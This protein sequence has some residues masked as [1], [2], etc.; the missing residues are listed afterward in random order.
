M[1]LACAAGAC[2]DAGHEGA[3]SDHFDGERFFNPGDAFD[4]NALDLIRYWWES[5]PGQW[6]R[7]LSTP[8]GPPPP[9]TVAAGALRVTFINHASVLI[10]A[11]GVNLLTDPIW[12]QRA[13]PVSWAG[14]QRYVPPGIAFDDLPEIDAVLISHDHYDHLD[15]PTLI[16]LRERFDPVIVVGLGQSA[17]LRRHGLINTVELDWWGGWKMPSGCTLWGAPSRHWTGRLTG[18]RNRSLWMSYVI[19]TPGGPVY[20]AGDTGYG[21]H[22]AQTRQRYGAMRYALLPIGAYKPRWLTDYQHMDPAQALQAHVDL[23][24]AAS[25]AV[26][27]G[28]FE[29]SDDGQHEP[30]RDLAAALAAR[31]MD[32]AAFH[33]PEFGGGYDVEPLIPSPGCSS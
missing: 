18:G 1:L 14:P 25:L 11:D 22:F 31:G 33:A 4:K 32:A 21:P 2:A 10:Q 30:P 13:S 3:A 8:P 28:T 27:F 29:L 7:D 12:S 26:H 17:L 20:F 23:D 5:E 24:A 16:R 9:A 15:L 6:S 19:E